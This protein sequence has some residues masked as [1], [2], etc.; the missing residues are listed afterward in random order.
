MRKITIGANL[1]PTAQW[2]INV[3]LEKTEKHKNR[4]TPQYN[5]K[6]RFHK[7]MCE[8]EMMTCTEKLT[9]NK[10]TLNAIIL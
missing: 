8:K 10:Q 1:V 5:K 4:I 7:D 9:D 2:F 3:A 6:I